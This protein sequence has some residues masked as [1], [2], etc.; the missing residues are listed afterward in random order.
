MRL[1]LGSLLAMA[2]LAAQQPQDRPT[3]LIAAQQLALAGYPELRAQGLQLRVDGAGETRITLGFASRDRDD[4]LG[5]S[6][7]REAQ[8]VVDATFDLNDTITAAVLR[9]PLAKVAERRRIRALASGWTEALRAEGATYAPDKPDDLLRDLN[10]AAF[11]KVLGRLT[12]TGASFQAGTAEDGLYWEVSA[13]SATGAPV[14][15][16]FEPYN[17]R[18]VRF[19][20]GGGQ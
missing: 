2:T 3:R 19:A 4:V 18:L 16:G 5:L 11:T 10:L 7:P 1:T 13:T 9:G 15:L 12:R 17:G 6:R 20:T 14:T 8:L